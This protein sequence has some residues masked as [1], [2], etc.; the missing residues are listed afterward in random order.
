M[1]DKRL[2]QE[3]RIKFKITHIGDNKTKLLGL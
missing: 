2:N 1:A 3:A